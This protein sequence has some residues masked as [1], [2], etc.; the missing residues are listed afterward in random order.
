MTRIP[1][2]YAVA[3]VVLAVP[4]QPL[5]QGAASGA[6]PRSAEILRSL[7]LSA[8]NHLGIL[9]YCQAQGAIGEDVVALHRRAM[10]TLPPA[11]VAGLEEAEAAGRQG[12]IVLDKPQASLADAA[13]ARGVGVGAAC[14]HM[15]MHVQVEAGQAP[16][17]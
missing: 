4:G 9:Q 7:H 12:M 5:A 13:R 17:W 11:Q 2:V 1:I 16:R 14:K 3:C 15:A 6:P 8:H 10:A